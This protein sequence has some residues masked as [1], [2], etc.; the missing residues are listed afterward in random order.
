MVRFEWPSI[1]KI[2]VKENNVSQEYTKKP[3]KN[4]VCVLFMTTGQA[5]TDKSAPLNVDGHL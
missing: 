2:G 3:E 5:L 4:E 1:C